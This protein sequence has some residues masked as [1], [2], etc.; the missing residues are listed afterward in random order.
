VDFLP[1]FGSD[2]GNRRYHDKTTAP[3]P[4]LGFQGKSGARRHLGERRWWNY[5]NAIQNIVTEFVQ[6]HKIV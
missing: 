3:K 5:P 6:K 4:Q 2:A 1:A